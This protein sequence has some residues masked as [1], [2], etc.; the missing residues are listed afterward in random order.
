M[1]ERTQDIY[2]EWLIKYGYRSVTFSEIYHGNMIKWVAAL[3]L[4][5]A[6]T[7]VFNEEQNTHNYT[8]SK[9]TKE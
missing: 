7:E 9:I 4:Q 8:L 1:D 3:K 5:N 6:L 2:N